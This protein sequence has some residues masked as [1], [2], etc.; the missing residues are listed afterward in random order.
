[1]EIDEIGIARFA[2]GK[3]REGWY[4]GDELGMMLQLNALHMLG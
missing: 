4:F 2:G 1:V 3:W